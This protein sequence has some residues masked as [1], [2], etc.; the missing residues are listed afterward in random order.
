MSSLFC[1]ASAVQLFS[2]C[3]NSLSGMFQHVFQAL[4]SSMEAMRGQLKQHSQKTQS[5]TVSKKYEPSIAINMPSIAINSHQYAALCRTH[6]H[7]NSPWPFKSFK[8]V[9]D[10]R[11]LNFRLNG[12]NALPNAQRLSPTSPGPNVGPAV[13]SD[14]ITI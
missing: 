6:R 8:C 4:S 3:F 2:S 12:S 7:L 5:P 13:N 14:D 11:W 1:N 9:V 10:C